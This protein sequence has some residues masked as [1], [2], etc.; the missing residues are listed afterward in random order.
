MLEPC[1][2]EAELAFSVL[3]IHRCLEGLEGSSSNFQKH[4]KL[5][6]VVFV[7]VGHYRFLMCYTAAE[8]HAFCG[9]I[10]LRV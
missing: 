8:L 4:S 9:K 7:F 6:V 2:G 5:N 1:E 10:N 3:Q